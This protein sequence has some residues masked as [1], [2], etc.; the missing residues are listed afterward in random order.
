MSHTTET[1]LQAAR[2]PLLIALTVGVAACAL[3]VALS[4]WAGL[5]RVGTDVLHALWTVPLLVVLH[6]V[7]LF[8]SGIGWRTL[9]QAPRPSVGGFTRLRVIREGV[10]VL[11][12]VAHVGGEVVGTSL[13]SRD[14]VG[15]GRAAASVI[16]D[17][18]MELL[19]LIA[20]LLAGLAALAALSGGGGSQVWVE[21]GLTGLAVV[22]GFVLAQ[23]FGLLRLLE[24]LVRRIAARFPSFATASLDGLHAEA[25]ATY[26][27]PLG[28]ARS[29]VLHL[30]A[31]SLGV[32]ESW[33]VMHALGVPVSVPQALVLESLGMAARSLGFAIP[34]ALA[35]QE[36]GFLL[37]AAALGLPAAPAL[38][39][40]LIKRLREVSVGLI[41]MGLWRWAG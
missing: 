25:L 12:P 1:G 7:Q 30:A 13:L 2:R 26:R 29:F 39:L 3:F 15:G 11:L 28:V 23:R 35:V 33:L 17:V 5:A 10:N 9:L 22:G 37:A 34:G 14:G 38:S 16:V 36:G 4:T 32:G 19:S 31:W 24:A 6:L 41:G 18:T 21:G 8:L 40:S 20:F 27:R